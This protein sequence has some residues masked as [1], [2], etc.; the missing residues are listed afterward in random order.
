ME[1]LLACKFLPEKR[2]LLVESERVTVGGRQ[3]VVTAPGQ[4]FSAV[5]HLFSQGSL[6]FNPGTLGNESER[7]AQALRSVREALCGVQF[8]RFDPTM[9]AV[10]VAADSTRRFRMDT[11]GFGLALCVDN[12]LGAD[13]DRFDAL[14]KQFRIIFPQIRSIVLQPRSG[15]KSP[16]D[17]STGAPDFQRGEGKGLYFRYEDHQAPI[18]AEQMS[19]GVLLVLAYLTVLYSP[20]PPRLVMLEEP[21]NGIHP[22]RLKDVLG[23]LRNLID[24]QHQTQVI[25]TTHSPYVVDLFKPEEVSLC[26]QTNAGVAVRNLSKSHKV[27]EQLGVFTLG[28]IWTSEGEEAISQ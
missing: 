25:L 5:S 16:V 7:V 22:G 10:P 21:E 27:R 24:A 15:Y 2:R 4:Q 14:E 8:Y 20:E 26:Q 12:I 6:S 17:D 9:L 11:N 1:Y 19:D 3:F 13:R 23:I 28:E 18:A